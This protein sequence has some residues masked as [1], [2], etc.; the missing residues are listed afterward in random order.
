MK[1]KQWKEHPNKE[2]PL[3]KGEI[4]TAKDRQRGCADM[5]N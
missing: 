3:L 2:K 4:F 1:S 5:G